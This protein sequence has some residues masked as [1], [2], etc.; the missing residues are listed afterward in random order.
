VVVCGRDIPWRS[1]D[2]APHARR[3]AP[4]PRFRRAWW[5]ICLVS[6]GSWA[7]DLPCLSLATPQWRGYHGGPRRRTAAA[8]TTR[9]RT[10]CRLCLPQ[11][12]AHQRRNPWYPA[13]PAPAGAPRNHHSQSLRTS[14]LKLVSLSGKTPQP[15]T[16]DLSPCCDHAVGS[17]MSGMKLKL[18]LHDIYNRGGDIDRAL[19]RSSTRPLPRRYRWSR[20]FPA[21]AP[22]RSRNVCCASWSRKGSSLSTTGWTRTRIT[23]VGSSCTSAGND[24]R[25]RRSAVPTQVDQPV[26]YG[27]FSAGG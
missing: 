10:G 16:D 13:D 14:S 9:S 1:E 24:R 17:T 2:P 18:D 20:S 6:G 19:R 26:R 3:H 21:R 12:R 8:A 5:R 7:R 4:P 25:R 23:L 22:A 15:D 27:S 11:K